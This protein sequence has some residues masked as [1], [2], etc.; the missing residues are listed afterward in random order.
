[1]EGNL[2]ITG[3]V[4]SDVDYTVT[5]QTGTPR[6][7]FRLASTP[8]FLK[9][10]QWTDDPTTWLTV[11]CWRHLAEHV[12]RSLHKGDPVIVVGRVRTQA[13]TDSNGSHQRMVLEATTV[14]H[15]LT[16]GSSRFEKMQRNEPEATDHE[17]HD[18]YELQDQSEA[19]PDA[20]AEPREEV[21]V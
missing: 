5:A 14:G 11:T 10:G 13:W 2:T 7:T 3:N 15:D 9:Q 21:A 19:S 6:A 12:S 1:M 18:A 16:R 8:R 17:A 20:L 4:G